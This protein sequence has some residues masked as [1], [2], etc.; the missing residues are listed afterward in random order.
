MHRVQPAENID[1]VKLRSNFVKLRVR[2]I[3]FLVIA[4]QPAATPP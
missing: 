3:V 1:S 4:P 2:L